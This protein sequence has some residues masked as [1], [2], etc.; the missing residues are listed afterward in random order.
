MDTVSPSPAVTNASLPPGLKGIRGMVL[1]ELK[2]GHRLTAREL[3]SRLRVSLNAVRH[4]LKELEAAAFIQY[5]R[6]YHGVGA[7]AFVYLLSPAGEAL[8]PRRYQAT[9][10]ELLDHVVEREGRAGAVAVL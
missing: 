6:Q 7:P 8:F 5:E 3:A 2:R 1:V 10:T 4:H 9:L